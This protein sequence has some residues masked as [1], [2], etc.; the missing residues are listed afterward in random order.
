M[1]QERRLFEEKI[2]KQRRSFENEMKFLPS[3]LCEEMPKRKIRARTPMRQTTKRKYP[4]KQEMEDK[5]R[6]KQ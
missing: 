3:K 2:D 4:I 6:R 5:K 1:N